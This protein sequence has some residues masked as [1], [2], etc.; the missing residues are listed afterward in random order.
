MIPLT[1]QEQYGIVTLAVLLLAGS[2]TQVICKRYPRVYDYVNLLESPRLYPKVDVNSA[3][4][5]ELTDIPYIGEYTARLL[6]RH[7]PFVNL[8]EIR[9]LPGIREKNYERFRN[10]LRVVPPEVERP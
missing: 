3:S 6:A 5:K 2:L 9:A 7:R 10:Y 4:E 1:K 8:E